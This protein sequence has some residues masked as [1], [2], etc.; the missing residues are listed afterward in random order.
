MLTGTEV[1]AKLSEMGCHSTDI[2]DALYEA[3]PAWAERHDSEVRART[4]ANERPSI[5][6][7]AAS[8]ARVIC[9][10]YRKDVT[11][12]ARRLV[13]NVVECDVDVDAE[14]VREYGILNVPAVAIRGDFDHP[15][16]VGARPL[17]DL[18]SLIAERV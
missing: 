2:T 13:L 5:L 18:L 9:D 14:L 10:P 3:D 16:I 6:Y 7:F 4:L 1:L 8:W 15:P 17:T 11:E 12:V